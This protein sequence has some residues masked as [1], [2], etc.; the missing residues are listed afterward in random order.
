MGARG[1]AAHGMP[2]RGRSRP[3]AAR[4]LVLPLA[5]ALAIPALAQQ[6]DRPGEE[7]VPWPE[8][9]PIPPS[10]VLSPERAL[11]SFRIAEG[12]RIELAAAEPLVEDP[13]AIAFDEDARL[14]VVE[15]R[16]FMPDIDGNGETEPT[17][18]I[19]I[20]SDQDD[21]GVYDRRTEFLTGL[22]L[23]RAVLPMRSGALVIEPPN[24]YF[25]RDADGD[26]RADEKVPVT[27]GF[28]AGIA[29]PEHA[30]NGL[31]WG[32]DNRIHLANHP[33]AL[34]KTD[35]G[36]DLLPAAG[37]GQWGLTQ[38]DQGRLYFDYNEDWLRA[39]LIPGHYAIRNAGAGTAS[40][41]N[42]RLARDT[43]VF[44]ARVTPGVNRGY[45]RGILANGKLVDRTSACGPGVYR[46][47]L[48]AE[49]R[50]DVFAC[51]AAANVV[52]RLVVRHGESPSARN[53]YDG[54][55]FLASTD[56]RFRPVNTA[57]GPDGGLYIVDMYRGVIQHRNF[58]TTYLRG[59]V[60][61]R[62]LEKP[63][64]LGRIWRVVP[65]G[66]PRKRPPRLSG[67]ATGDLVSFLRH[68]NGEVRDRAQQ[69]LVERG[70]RS[71]VPILR[72]MARGDPSPLARAHAF[73]TLEGL[74]S[75]DRGDV[76][77]ALRDEDESMRCF[78]IR[79][80]EPL[81]SRGDFA[82]WVLCRELA[83]GTARVRWQLAASYGEVRGRGAAEAMQALSD[84]AWEH[85]SDGILRGV[86]LSSLSRSEVAMVRRLSA[87]PD[88]G[89]ERPG[90]SELLAELS[91]AAC[92]HRDA[93]LQEELFS[94]AGACMANWQQRALLRGAVRALPKGGARRGFFAFAETPIALAAMA[95]SGDERTR[96][97]VAEILAAIEI[98]IETAAAREL[99][100]RLR[101]RVAN[102]ARLFGFTCASCH[103]G[104]GRGMAGLAPPLLD[105]EW[106]AGPADRLARIALR[107]VRGPIEVLG[108]TW[109]L[110]MPGH[111]KM[112]DEDL[113]AILSYLRW[114]FGGK[115]DPVD[116]ETL[117]RVR[118]E[119]GARREPFTAE[120]LQAIR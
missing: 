53:P 69:S 107:G 47:A 58:V 78:G 89:E 90:R 61:A 74:S 68:E 93:S 65:D 43:S 118:A 81:L 23:P 112:P 114:Q 98:R 64:G 57:T 11:A 94:A 45:R 29:N 80:A 67:L 113:A 119:I 101:A 22:V 19:A 4:I 105:S 102:G 76:L 28:D 75:L 66:V 18:I 10:P 70:D 62:G 97:L 3:F 120:E 30:G 36:F 8:D 31:L 16:S 54:R 56:E 17:G 12:Y 39:D 26:S 37:H 35:R 108:E 49:C 55:E 33:L 95:R 50:G 46:G 32:I 115:P 5:T 103:Q 110:E 79:L 100:P 34:R 77:F 99:P 85:A 27:G 96:D 41:G 7:Q 20:L 9:I 86:V 106:V 73:W 91:R 104:H 83:A 13:V 111:D 14:W 15:M 1:A 92:R 87:R 72:R 88:F 117:A 82:A 6:G 59:Q 71:V 116:E 48:L 42:Y 44:P 25:A 109:S 52:R 2:A 84:L 21:D 51:D 63:L 24:L 40:A 38:D 60:E